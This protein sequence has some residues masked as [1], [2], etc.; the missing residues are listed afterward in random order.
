[1]PSRV[2]VKMHTSLDGFV[3]TPTGDTEWL[4]PHMDE[5]VINWEVERLWQA[6]FHI[7]GRNL[8]KIM[9]SYWPT[10]TEP[11]AA[12]MNEIPKVVFSNTLKQTAWGDTRIANGDLSAEIACLKQQT[13]KDIL[14]HGGAAFVQSLS[15]LD[16]VDEYRFLIH[17]IALGS[18][19]P[20]FDSLVHLNLMSSHTFPSG[21]VALTYSRA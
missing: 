10:S 9:T 2:I 11:P 21:V 17:P 1:M 15:R 13:E 12:P 3:C 18:G 4:F 6:G 19:K 20:C 7:M 5:N 14:A 16:L 8:Y